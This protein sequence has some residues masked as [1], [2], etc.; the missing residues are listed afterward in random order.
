MFQYDDFIMYW[1]AQL[2]IK[3]SNIYCHFLV[4]SGLA[5]YI[6]RLVLKKISNTELDGPQ[7][8]EV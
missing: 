4:D 8:W 2:R 6:C 1:T 5:K 3:D 7:R